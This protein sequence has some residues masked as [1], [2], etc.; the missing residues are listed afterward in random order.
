MYEL[1]WVIMTDGEME[2]AILRYC[3]SLSMEADSKNGREGK[4]GTG[5]LDRKQGERKGRASSY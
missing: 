3:C 1:T 4:E 2:A 5:V